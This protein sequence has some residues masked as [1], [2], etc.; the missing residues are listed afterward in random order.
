MPFVKYVLGNGQSYFQRLSAEFRGQ[1]L[2]IPDG[3]LLEIVEP[4]EVNGFIIWLGLGFLILLG[5]ILFVWIIAFDQ[6]LKSAFEPHS[7]WGITP[8]QRGHPY[9]KFLSY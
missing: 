7:V 9:P 4:T 1:R 2:S 5:L 8:C 6:G 3:S